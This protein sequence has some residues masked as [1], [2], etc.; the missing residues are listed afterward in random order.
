M[1]CLFVSA[2]CFNLL[3]NLGIA[4]DESNSTTLPSHGGWEVRSVSSH[5]WVLH[6]RTLNFGVVSPRW[7]GEWFCKAQVVLVIGFACPERLCES[8]IIVVHS[9]HAILLYLCTGCAAQGSS[10]YIARSTRA[11]V[12]WPS[13]CFSFRCNKTVLTSC[14]SNKEGRCAMRLITCSFAVRLTVRALLLDWTLSMPDF[15][16]SSETSDPCGKSVRKKWWFSKGNPLISG[17]S[18]LLKYYSIWP[19]SMAI[20]SFPRIIT[21]SPCY[22]LLPQIWGMEKSTLW[23]RLGLLFWKP[24]E[25]KQ[26]ENT[27]HHL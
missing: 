27:Q 13:G 10:S 23:I 17:K 15:L 11:V 14:G 22:P 8:W 16:R 4:T 9:F 26:T 24:L 6:G 7:I 3:A 1:G 25:Y 18:R 20:G 2:A 5:R 19:E 21:R 12:K